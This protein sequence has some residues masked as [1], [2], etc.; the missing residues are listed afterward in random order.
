MSRTTILT[1]P[2]LIHLPSIIPLLTASLK[3]V[4]EFQSRTISSLRTR[5][6]SWAMLLAALNP[7]LESATR[8]E[9]ARLS[10][11]TRDF[12]WSCPYFLPVLSIAKK[13]RYEIE[14]V[15]STCMD[16]SSPYSRHLLWLEWLNCLRHSIFTAFEIFLFVFGWIAIARH[17]S[18]S[19]PLR[20]KHPEL[21]H[22]QYEQ[23]KWGET[24]PHLQHSESFK[25]HRSSYL[26]NQI[27]LSRW[28]LTPYSSPPWSTQR[29][30]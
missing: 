24:L 12:R 30:A 8:K 7:S 1:H 22:V 26:S 14:F 17:P 21:G 20:Q 2:L 23:K 27:N 3:E 13:R 28:P 19:D 18:L 29:M 15:I 10:T 9:G 16:G 11:V 6:C 25:Q 5:M 4:Q